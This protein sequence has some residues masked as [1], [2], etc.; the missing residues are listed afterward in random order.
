MIRLLAGIV[1][2]TLTARAEIG[3]KEVAMAY[4]DAI[5]QDDLDLLEDTALSPGTT[6]EKTASIRLRLDHLAEELDRGDCEVIEEKREG[7]LAAILISQVTEFDPTGVQIHAIGLIKREENW[8]PAPVPASFENTGI[9]YVPSMAKQ[10]EKL[11]AWML[12]QRAARLE[13]VRTSIREKL[14]N[15][16]RGTLTKD[17]LFEGPPEK[18]VFDFIEACRNSRLPA[19]L[20]YLGGLEDPLPKGWDETV[21]VTATGLRR[22]PHH[23]GPWSRLVSDRVLRAVVHTETEKSRA[24]V[25]IGDFDPVEAR[26]GQESI[27]IRELVLERNE[28]GFWRLKLPG[29]LVGADDEELS[30]APSFFDL[31]ASFPVRLFESA[32]PAG[33]ATPEELGETFLSKVA[34]PSLRSILPFIATDDEED[35]MLALTSYAHLW[36]GFRN[37]QQ[38]RLL[39][40]CET[41]GDEG[42][43]LYCELDPYNPELR[44]DLIREL[45]LVRRPAGWRLAPDAAP[46]LEDFT[47]KLRLWL[48]KSRDQSRADWLETLGL[49]A[50][51]GGLPADSAPSEEDARAA[52]EAWVA[53]LQSRKPRR[54]F[55]RV[56]IFDDDEGIR[57]L[58]AYLG[59]ELPSRSTLEILGMHRFGRWAAVSIR[60]QPP[61]P[62]D[63]P[64]NLLHPIVSTPAGAKVLPE[65]ILYLADTRAREFLN[66]DVW[67]RL[68][69]RLP[70]S[71]VEELKA[72]HTAHTELCREADG[73]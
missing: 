45:R 9:S 11:E 56:A 44:R 15:D 10:A 71:A 46:R 60:H 3:P 2:L 40:D 8:L 70:E 42:A 49:N 65:G 31:K 47:D 1:C 73:E 68:G 41:D 22:N 6:A 59:Q 50:R 63:P 54:I 21:A 51:L 57:R 69:R 34:D 43:A 64:F 17:E 13:T 27:G 55:E 12:D 48:Q 33:F 58:F 7:D 26:P 18:L 36:R 25:S 29:W 61:D 37:S 5:R 39:L 62:E 38:I 23:T 35:A 66:A 67:K 52:A 4:L 72:A 16:V 53:A 19:A 20:A 30:A 28:A 32:K 24:I 14:L